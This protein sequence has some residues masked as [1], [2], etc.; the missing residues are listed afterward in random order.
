MAI[1]ARHFT[2]AASAAYG[3]LL[4][5]AAMP[6][7][8]AV[9]LSD[10][11]LFLT[12]SVPPNVAVTLDDS[13]S[14]ARAFVPDICGANGNSCN[15][16]TNRYAKSAYYNPLYYDPNIKYPPAKTAGGTDIATSFTSA[17]RNG[18]DSG[19]GTVDL[20]SK[21]RP[22]AYLNRPPGGSTSEDY[23][24]HYNGG[25]DLGCGSNSC[26][27]KAYYYVFNKS[28]SSCNGTSTDNDCYTLV[29]VGSSSG[30]GTLDLNGD[31]RIDS[32]DKDERQNFANWYSFYRTRNL[33]TT[34]AAS[35]AFSKLDQN[36]RIAWQ[37]LNSCH[38]SGGFVTSNCSGTSGSLGFSNAIRPYSGTQKSNFYTWL[39]NLPTNNS[40][41]LPDAMARAGD[42]FRMGGS[43]GPYLNDYS[44]SSKDEYSCRR[45]YHIMMTDGIWNTN[46]TNPGNLDNQT[47]TLPTNPD[48]KQ[49]APISPYKDSY[50]NT[51]ADVAF[52]YWV[53]DLRAG[54]NPAALDNILLPIYNDRTGTA[55]QQYWN[56]KNDPATWQHMVNFTI[57][58]G[59]GDYLSQATPALTY[60]GSTYS[61]SYNDLVSGATK[62]P[63]PSPDTAANVADLWHAALNSRGQFFSANNP[64]ALGAAFQTILT[65]ISGDTGSAASLSANSTSIQPG[66]TIVYQAR[67]NRDWSGGLLAFPVDTN[68]VGTAL[69]DASQL[70]P[71]YGVRKIYTFNGTAGVPFTSCS[72]LSAAEK[73]ALDTDINGVV[74]SRCS[75]R[76]SWLRGNAAKEQRNGGSFRN[77]LTTVMGDI[78]NSD[79]AYVA[80]V[81][82]GY[83]ALPAGTPGQDSYATF[84]SNNTSRMPMVYVGANDGRLYG[85]RADQGSAQSGVEQFSYIPAGVYGNLSRLTDPAYSHR[86]YADGPITVGDAYLGSSWKT[87]LIAGLNAGGKS[88]YAL[89]VTDPTNFDE[90]KV[91][92]EFND[93][94]ASTTLGLTFSQPQIGLL[95][96]GTWVAVFGNGYNSTSGGAYLYVVNLRTGALIKKI[97]ASD[98]AGDESNGLSTPL[99]VDTDGNKLM[100]T[101]YAGDL[102]GHLW[103]FDLSGDPATWG[104][105]Y[106]GAPLFTARN[107]S[108]QVQPITSQPKAAGHPLGGK[109]ILFGTGRYLSTSD[110]FDQT[111]QTF[112]GIR[113]NG[114]AVTTTDRSELQEQRIQLQQD[115]S[116]LT[117]RTVSGNTVDWNTK[118]GYYLDLVDPPIPPGTA[119]GERVVSTPLVTSD[120]VI[121]VTVIPSTDPCVPG[122]TSWLME[123]NLSTGGTFQDSI[124]D[125][126]RD[127]KI[128]ETD[129]V[130]GQIVSGEKLTSLGISKTPV[131]LQHDPGFDKLLTGTTGRIEVVRN[132]GTNPPVGGVTRRSWI[133]I[134]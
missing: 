13:G 133:Q 113:D 28:N 50:S 108:G 37:A 6:A 103:K 72:N 119:M 97:T 82:Y 54:S 84:I 70:I 71:A 105:A 27:T 5:L 18:F 93:G 78:I 76:L 66:N 89:D 122:G 45:N 132:Q 67:F 129:K 121:F 41:P 69:W 127:G 60:N 75:D 65:A 33:A 73:L 26:K 51:L 38:G 134:R 106:S 24:S 131:L 86:Y 88:V 63:Q 126:N 44:G 14:M 74:D 7:G 12:V 83:A 100:D 8:S 29:V 20:S 101:V 115:A 53:E 40:T 36:A 10:A 62:W 92:W 9:S 35:V 43:N 21:Y 111:V 124:L 87:V 2:K 32:S 48:M 57:G 23:M 55:T 130:G 46:N 1:I 96:N 19:Y 81:N 39:G 80:D 118:K 42:Y 98:T 77:R 104:V 125:I 94:G 64:A 107:A 16:L 22:T 47:I 59:L 109:V 3:A 114:A 128:D 85:I 79:P 112:Y 91:M 25:G 95:E 117:V 15:T 99:L 123:L 4:V 58:L 30:T 90:S 17:L 120:R 52:K 61:G 116:G 11:P 31:G 68:G 102:Q 34:S 56:P 49:Y 110:V